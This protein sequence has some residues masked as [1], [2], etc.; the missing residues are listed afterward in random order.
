MNIH[1]N[2]LI[3]YYYQ[4]SFFSRFFNSHVMLTICYFIIVCNSR[5]SLE[6]YDDYTLIT[7]LTNYY[8]NNKLETLKRENWCKIYIANSSGI[9]CN[10]AVVID[11]WRSSKAGPKCLLIGRSRMR[12]RRDAKI[13]HKKVGSITAFPILTDFRRLNETSPQTYCRKGFYKT[14]RSQIARQIVKLSTSSHEFAKNFEYS[15]SLS[16]GEEKN[17]NEKRPQVKLV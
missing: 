2:F 11:T 6:I 17:E 5:K 9:F 4:T 8:I 14:S 16:Q 10:R 12:G 3:N 15:T 13:W 7:S 1:E